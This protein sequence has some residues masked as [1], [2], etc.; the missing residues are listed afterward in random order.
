MARGIK[1]S[2]QIKGIGFVSALILH[3]L[4]IDTD[5]KTPVG[6]VEL[7]THIF[8]DFKFKDFVALDSKKAGRHDALYSSIVQPKFASGW[9]EGEGLVFEDTFV[10]WI[11]ENKESFRTEKATVLLYSNQLDLIVSL[12]NTRLEHPH[13]SFIF[14]RLDCVDEEDFLESAPDLTIFVPDRENAD[15][16]REVEKGLL[17]LT[18]VMGDQRHCVFCV[19][20]AAED[21]KALQSRFQYENMLSIFSSISPDFFGELLKRLEKKHSSDPR[22]LGLC[23]FDP[24]AKANFPFDAIVTSI[25]ENE[26]TFKT[27]QELPY[28]CVLNLETPTPVKLVTI[29]S[30]K[31]LSPFPDGHHY[32]AFI[33]GADFEEQDYLR[34][35]VNYAINNGLKVFDYVHLDDE[36][37]EKIKSNAKEKPDILKEEA[38]LEFRPAPSKE[39]IEFANVGHF[40]GKERPKSKKGPSKL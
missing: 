32:M 7:E 24:R 14:R 6:E 21:T 33:C 25:T 26:I 2:A 12:E 13:V 39:G 17:R 8:E 28:Y 20:N 34:R 1:A 10:T 22:S 36:E 37:V 35:F 38:A 40:H 23:D 4:T 27:R 5:I 19:F 18:R 30:L 31:P 16:A 15:H 11:E 29:P 3:A 9:D